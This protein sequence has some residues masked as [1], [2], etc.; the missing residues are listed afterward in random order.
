MGEMNETE[1]LARIEDALGR[2]ASVL[3]RFTPGAVEV[4][5]KSGHD[6]VTEADRAVDGALRGA[7]LRDGEGW[8]SEETADSSARLQNDRLWVVDPL[9]GTRE[10]VQGI[11]E[12]CVS[13]GWVQDGQAMAGGILNPATGETI[14]G[15]RS[16]G[17]RRNGVPM[18]VSPRKE[19]PGALVLGSRSEFKRGEW[20][21][22]QDGSLELRAVGSVAYKLALV[23][24]GL[25]DATWTLVPKHEW[26]VAAGTALVQ[27]AGGIVRNLD[28]SPVFFNQPKPWLPG[29]I[30][31]G[32][33]LYPEISR[34]LGISTAAGMGAR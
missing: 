13:I 26:D 23:A 22:F 11:P 19:L 7:L 8:L 9:D 33:Q 30:A 34:L 12:W 29:L 18:R 3:S 25:A 2:A 15:S 20:K 31:A 27:A 4:E 6:P 1:V 10:F 17:V 24:A 28:G 21:Q 14:I 32:P 5:Y 16:T